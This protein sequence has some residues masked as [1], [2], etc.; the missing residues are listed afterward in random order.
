M[1]VFLPSISYYF[2]YASQDARVIAYDPPGLFHTKQ[3]ILAVI[4]VTLNEGFFFLF[5]SL[6]LLPVAP[7]ATGPLVPHYPSAESF[8]LI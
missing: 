7:S 1:E 8:Q 6:P 2:S 3:S 5:G 4:S